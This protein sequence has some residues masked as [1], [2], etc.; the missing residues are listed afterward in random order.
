VSERVCITGDTLSYPEGGGHFWVY[1][2]W[3][4]GLRAFGCEVI[5]LEVVAPEI[6]APALSRFYTC[7]KQR[8]ERYGFGDSLVL[9]GHVGQDLDS[10]A[11]SSWRGLDAAADADLLINLRYDLSPAILRRFRR[12]ALLDIDPGLL[13]IW[14]S[15]GQIQV[16]RH[17]LY[18]TTGET[19][20]RAGSRCP[21]VGLPWRYTPP[22]VALDLWPVAPFAP[23]A[24]FSTISHWSGDEWVQQGEEIYINDKRAGFLPFLDLP[25][26]VSVPLE[27][28]LRLAPDEEEDR[29]MLQDRG[30]RLVDSRT[31][32][33]QPWD[34]QCYIQLSIGEFSAVKP[35]CVHLQNAWISDRSLCY[36]ASG[37]PVVVQHTGPSRFLP[38]AEGLFR[39]HTLEEA[40]TSL[41]AVKSDYDRHSRMARALAVEYFDAAR[42][43]AALLERAL[44]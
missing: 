6:D 38:D 27:L 7:L 12:T 21:D 34:Y 37:K 22:C 30:W 26:Y 33:A 29:V 8:L 43:T 35:S 40:A 39:F 44:P 19:V 23:D 11:N 18:F 3:A 16:S 1:L 31:V 2:N 17:D 5:W 25:R 24:A 41:K 42:V 9:C 28:A 20:G 36:L 13:Q 10:I 14:M 15:E 32:S 4:L